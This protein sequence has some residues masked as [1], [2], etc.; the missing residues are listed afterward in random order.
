MDEVIAAANDDGEP[1]VGAVRREATMWVVRLTSGDVTAEDQREFRRWRDSDRSHAAALAEAREL[2]LALGPML[3]AGEQKAADSGRHQRQRFGA[4]AAALI[5]A[6]IGGIAAHDRYGHDY[7]TGSGELR[8]IALADGTRVTLAGSS[9]IDVAYDSNGRGVKL[10]RGEA[11]FNVVH[12]TSRPFIVKAGPGRV[13]DVGTAFSV[14]RE[15]GGAAVEVARGVVKVA[16]GASVRQ[17]VLGVNQAVDFD[18][19]GPG[20]IRKIDAAKK[21][22][23]INGRLVI[24]SETLS[25]TVS[26]I[27]RYYNGH[28]ILLRD[29]SRGRPISAVI[30]LAN[31]DDWLAALDRTGVA[32]VSKIGSLVFLH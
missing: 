9:A 19:N 1:V 8:T 22:S 7:T 4:I 2:W 28:V 16:S 27:N 24:E 3:E 32:K 26:E 18:A 30:D 6:S 11:F 14:R 10:V 29:Q 15:S 5:L 23:W 31:I 20:A 21:L 12:E 13:E 25:E 17:V